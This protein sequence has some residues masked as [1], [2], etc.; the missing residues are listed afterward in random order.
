VK[1][2]QDGRVHAAHAVRDPER[3]DRILLERLERPGL[4]A[5]GRILEQGTFL[6][7]DILDLVEHDCD[8]VGTCEERLVEL[9]VAAALERV[10]DIVVSGLCPHIL[11]TKSGRLR[12]GPR[13]LGLADAGRA[14]KEYVDAAAPVASKRSEIA[15][16][17]VG[18]LGQVREMCERQLGCRRRLDRERDETLDRIVTAEHGSGEALHGLEH[19]LE[20]A[21]AVPDLEDARSHQATVRRQRVFDGR[22]GNTKDDC[23][24]SS[25][26]RQRQL[27]DAFQRIPEQDVNPRKHAKRHDLLLQLAEG[28]RLPEQAHVVE[29]PAGRNWRL[30]L[31]LGE[32]YPEQCLF[33][34]E[35]VHPRTVGETLGQFD[36]V[37]VTGRSE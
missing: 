24:D 37:C 8:V 2:P 27:A 3:R 22:N 33:L 30:G 20:S 28:K 10:E 1:T 6:A 31:E 21:E 15:Q 34:R 23:R 9:V 13:E 36:V 29:Q 12:E 35:P 5:N 32:Y 18:L 11:Q 14:V 4:A 26:A 7:E 19:I 25:N 16:D 17:Q